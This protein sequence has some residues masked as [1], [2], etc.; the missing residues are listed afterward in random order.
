M[1]A[2]VRLNPNALLRLDE[3]IYIY[4]YMKPKTNI[5]VKIYR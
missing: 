1:Y 3:Y 5:C 4:M 2:V